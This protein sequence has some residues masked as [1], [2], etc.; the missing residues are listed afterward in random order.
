MSLELIHSVDLSEVDGLTLLTVPTTGQVMTLNA[1]A[2]AMVEELQK[3]SS[4][5]ELVQTL[6]SRFDASDEAQV[7]LDV[8]ALLF[9]LCTEGL[10]E[11]DAL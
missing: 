5:A 10:L 6:C 4:R 8:D 3:G 1:T 9:D 11:R 7:R 2:A